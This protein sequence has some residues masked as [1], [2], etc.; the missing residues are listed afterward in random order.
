VSRGGSRRQ[1]RREYR[2]EFRRNLNR[3]PLPPHP[4]RDSAFFYGALSG[5]LLGIVY[6]TGGSLLR[7]L[8]VGAAFFV[9]ATGFSWWRFRERMKEPEAE[10]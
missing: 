7:A 9:L 6:A 8:V 1:R 2:S 3:I 4:Y 10:Q 5:C